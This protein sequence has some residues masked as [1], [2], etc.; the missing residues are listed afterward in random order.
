VYQG[1][2]DRADPDHCVM[3]TCCPV[4]EVAGGL[5]PVQVRERAEG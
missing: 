2:S 5:Q 4:S 1:A 3:Q